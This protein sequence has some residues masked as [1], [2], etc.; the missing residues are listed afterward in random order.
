MVCAALALLL[1][2]AAAAERGRPGTEV[3]LPNTRV[4][5][6]LGEHQGYEISFAMPNPKVAVIYASTMHQTTVSRDL[7][8]A[9]YAVHPYLLG[10][11]ARA[12]FGSL[13]NLWVRFV[14]SGEVRRRKLPAGCKGPRPVLELGTLRGHAA[15]SGEGGYFQLGGP[16]RTKALRQ[17]SSRMIC[18]PRHELDLSSSRRLRDHAFFPPTV[19]LYSGQDGHAVLLASPQGG[20]RSVWLRAAQ[21]HG[22]LPGADVQAVTFEGRRDIAIGRIAETQGGGSGVLAT[23]PAGVHSA[24]ATLAPPAPFYGEASFLENSATSHSWTGSLGVKLPGLDQP[25]TGASFFTGLCVIGPFE[26]PA[27]CNPA[28][29]QFG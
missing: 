6:S 25:L 20:D 24:T 11:A 9:A 4:T 19:P 5:A 26:V 7:E 13:G 10:E 23:S 8:A 14:P 3:L 29:P 15:L 16:V 22:V 28:R 1:P 27:A 17:R 18:G 12:E 21:G 2:A